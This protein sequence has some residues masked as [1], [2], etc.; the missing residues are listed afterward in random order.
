MIQIADT[1]VS[2]DLVES[3]F[4]CELGRCRGMCCVEGDSG[5]PLE[6]HEC[7]AIRKNLSSVWDE[8]S[9]QARKVI[10]TSGI[11]YRDRE[12]ETVTSLVD[13]R[14]CVFVSMRE[15]G[16]CGCAFEKAYIDG[17]STF[18][19]PVSCYLYPVRVKKLKYY[20]AVNYDRWDICCSGVASGLRL[21]VPLYRFL[22]EPLIM[23]FGKEW[24]EALEACAEHLKV[25]G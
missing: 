8:L 23:R 10:N 22:R 21:G 9:P 25:K 18:R 15:D 13:G 3:Y 5:A 14:E 4:S 20:I 11:C 12:G 24:Y 16:S 19:K 1:L 2:R 7:E 17:R 6:E